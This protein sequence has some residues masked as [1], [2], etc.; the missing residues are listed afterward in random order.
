MFI[1]RHFAAIRLTRRTLSGITLILALT[2]TWSS[3]KATTYYVDCSAGTNG[4]GSSSSPWNTI[5]SVNATTF[6][7]GDAILFW[8][9]VSWSDDIQPRDLERADPESP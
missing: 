4:S 7:P 3:A 9:A 8:C 2:F 1:P 6:S 5:T